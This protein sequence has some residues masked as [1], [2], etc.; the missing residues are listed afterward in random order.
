M[1]IIK[2]TIRENVEAGNA[3]LDSVR[4]IATRSMATSVCGKKC[5]SVSKN[6]PFMQR[7]RQCSVECNGSE[8]ELRTVDYENPGSNPVLHC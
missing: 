7:Q 6:K 3:R 2:N 8:V 1:E 4:G 5:H